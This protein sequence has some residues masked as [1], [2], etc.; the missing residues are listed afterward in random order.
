L[1]LQLLLV[2]VRTRPSQTLTA[3]VAN[4][5]VGLV[6]KRRIVRFGLDL[7]L[8]LFNAAD[9]FVDDGPAVEQKALPVEFSV[10]EVVDQSYFLLLADVEGIA[11]AEFGEIVPGGRSQLGE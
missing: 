10:D 8:Y 9:D 5:F 3:V 2:V 6:E 7:G 11:G 4:L 1:L